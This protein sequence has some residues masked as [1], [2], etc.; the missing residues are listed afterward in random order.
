[1]AA[2]EVKLPMK[3]LLSEFGSTNGIFIDGGFFQFIA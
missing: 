3:I 1:M 2:F